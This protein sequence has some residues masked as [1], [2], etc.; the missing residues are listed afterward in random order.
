MPLTLEHLLPEALGGR[1]VSRLL[2]KDCN[3]RFGH[4]LEGRAK[5]D[6]TIRQLATKLRTEMPRLAE[7]L[8]EGQTY[9]TVGPGVA[10][11]G[12]IKGSDFVVHATKLPDGSLIQPTPTALLSIEKMLV[13]EGL[14]Q[15]QVESA[16]RRFKEAPENV[17]LSLS[18]GIDIVKWSVTGLRPSLDGPLLN[19]L[20][21]V[22]SAYEFL[23]LHVGTAIYQDTPSL[24]AIR[25]SLCDGKL[26]AQHVEVERLRAP[27]FRPF[28]GLV[29]EGNHPHAKVQVR[30]F[31]QLAFRVHFKRLSVAGPRGMYTH[32]LSSNEEQVRQLPQNDA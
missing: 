28:H 25:K 9:V 1:L 19:N 30:L 23:A 15:T 27:D 2:C 8:Q 7:R 24:T 6:P 10:S 5:S 29:F 3:S 20:V 18:P 16:L 32:D 21:P 12:Y 26:D 14:S 17:K 22:K 31:G 13:R 11:K 4:A